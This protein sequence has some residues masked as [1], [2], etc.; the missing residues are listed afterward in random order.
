MSQVPPQEIASLFL[1]RIVAFGP[2]S[3]GPV[4]P[5]QT[6]QIATEFVLIS[7][8]CGGAVLHGSF[9]MHCSVHV[10]AA[11]LPHHTNT[12]EPFWCDFCKLEHTN[13]NADSASDQGGSVAS[14]EKLGM[15]VI[16]KRGRGLLGG[17]VGVHVEEGAYCSAEGSFW[18]RSGRRMVDKCVLLIAAA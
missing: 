9:F 12:A 6:P 2:D 14:A 1:R 16:A 17:L 5:G 10:L 11:W 7:A 13:V 4:K 18:V 8:F 15:I 3:K